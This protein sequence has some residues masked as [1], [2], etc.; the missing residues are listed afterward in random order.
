MICTQ[1]ANKQK[2]EPKCDTLW[3][4]VQPTPTGTEPTHEAGDD[5]DG[6][7][8]TIWN[9]EG[10]QAR[11]NRQSWTVQR[12]VE[13]PSLQQAYAFV[14]ELF[15]LERIIYVIDIDIDIGRS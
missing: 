6:K 15:V 13:D 11:G 8:D 4:N 9:L 10:V 3:C 2:T 7:F 14:W 12:W 1:W 5:D